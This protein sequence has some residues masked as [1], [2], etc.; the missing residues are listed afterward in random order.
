MSKWIKDLVGEYDSDLINTCLA[1]PPKR[2]HSPFLQK[3]ETPSEKPRS[4]FL[5]FLYF[6]YCFLASCDFLNF[7]FSC[8]RTITRYKGI[9]LSQKELET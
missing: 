7:A 3:L 9:N 2:R 1:H 8:N 6:T 4:A 5:Y